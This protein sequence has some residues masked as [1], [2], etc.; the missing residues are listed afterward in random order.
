[1]G[2]LH[3]L[4]HHCSSGSPVAERRRWRLPHLSLYPPF[5][6]HSWGRASAGIGGEAKVPE[7][8]KMQPGLRRC[9]CGAH[10]S[11]PAFLPARDESEH[12]LLQAVDHVAPMP[13]VLDTK[14]LTTAFGRGTE[15]ATST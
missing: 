14:S 12:Q 5:S 10:R 7:K 1:M 13:G 9:D 6:L 3:P 11:T 4:W 8:R 15:R 2:S